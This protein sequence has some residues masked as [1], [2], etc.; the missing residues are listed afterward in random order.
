MRSSLQMLPESLPG[1]MVAM[2]SSPEIRLAG[3]TRIEKSLES[4][5][6]PSVCSSLEVAIASMRYYFD[7]Q[8]DLPSNH[9]RTISQNQMYQIQSN[10]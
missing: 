10:L 2:R 9:L 8:F 7:Q 3:Q 1:A 5:D 6:L 4:P